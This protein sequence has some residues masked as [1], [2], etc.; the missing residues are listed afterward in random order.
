LEV[1]GELEGHPDNV[2]PAI[3]GGFTIAWLSAPEPR[4]RVAGERN[5]RVPRARATT[6][7]PAQGIEPVVFVP[8]NQ[9]LTTAARAALP[10]HVPHRDA[11][12]NAGRSALLVHALT[13]EPTLLFEATEDRLHQGY[14]AP[15]MPATAA[16][17]AE[18]RK[19]GI[20]AV[21]S[22]AGPTVLALVMAESQWRL[23][24]FAASGG[25]VRHNLR[26][27]LVGAAAV[28]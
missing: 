19:A 7:S 17:V 23:S 6:L 14:R 1:A 22:G 15:G 28:E 9:G 27:D 2:A 12:F 11:A 5:A 16:L 8:Q 26:F 20:P 24:G 4:S 3:L 25:W 18:I 13:R 21:V 10:P